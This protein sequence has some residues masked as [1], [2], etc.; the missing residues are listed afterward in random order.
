MAERLGNLGY[1]AVGKETTPGT[2]VTPGVFVPL[3]E[4]S[5][6]TNLNHV[7][8]NPVVGLPWSIYQVL[9]GQRDHQGKV[10]VM[11]EPNTAA[12]LFD[13][14]MTVG[15]VSGGGPYTWPFTAANA[16]NSY[17]VDI[18]TGVQV[19]RFAGVYAE[20][21][22]MAFKENEGQ[23]DIDL[24]GLIAFSARTIVSATYSSPT[25]TFV[26]DTNYDPS[27]T[28]GLVVG[29]TMQIYSVSG[30]TYQ[31][32]TIATITNGTTFTATADITAAL[33]DIVTIKPQTSTFSNLTPFLWSRTFFTF[34]ATVAACVTAG[35]AGATPLEQGSTWSITHAFENKAGSKR[36]GSFDPA[37]LPRLQYSATLKA[38]KYF[39][40]P[41]DEAA[42]ADLTKVACV[43]THLSG[44]NDSLTV[45]YHNMKNMTVKPAVKS[46]AIL[47][48]EEEFDI[49]YDSTDALAAGVTVI[50]AVATGP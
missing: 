21:I 8:D 20:S 11:A 27:P 12:Y 17:T 4:E 1:F 42:W 18:S 40:T 33:G 39:D 28:T 35:T 14:L 46:A 45:T 9:P 26:L 29:D 34:G 22:A 44:T 41:I 15:S 47:Y 48:S 7:K 36:S 5:M 19:F 32:F 16:S 43:I 13:M 49:Q 37:S 31:S 3:Y 23:F 10:T 38:T 24:S 2:A 30:G 6:T 50:N 25:T